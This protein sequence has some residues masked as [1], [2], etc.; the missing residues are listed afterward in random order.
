MTAMV[1][2]HTQLAINGGTPVRSTPFG[3][4]PLWD[5]RDEAALLG[6]LRSG[7]WGIGGDE[8]ERFEQELAEA[9]GARYALTVTNG[10]AA[11]EAAL[12]ACGVGYGDEVIVPPYTF[13]ATASAVLLVGGIP[14]FADI[15]PNTFNIDPNTIEALITPRTKAIVPVHIGGLPADMD[16]IM[17]IAKRHNLLVLEDA[18]QS[19]GATW[20]GQWVGTIGD[21]GCYSFQSS[22]NIN[23]GEGGVIITSNPE[24]EEACWAFK[25]CGRVR[26]GQWYQHDT[27]GDNFR[28][29]QFQAAILRSQMTRF[30]EWAVL[31]ER[32]GDY[33][34]KGLREL[35]GLA[36]VVRDE[37]VTRHAYHIIVTRYD[38]SAF[39]G[40]SR[41]RFMEA[42]KAE[43][44]PC[45]PGYRPIYTTGGIQKGEQ[46][47]RN[48]LGL[49]EAP[50]PN[51]P[52]TERI[53]RE[54]AMWLL[55]QSA[56]LGSQSDMDDILTAVEKI[57][58]AAQQG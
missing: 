2:Q 47:L 34:C 5:E 33:L 58:K 22:K 19:I 9:A 14:V 50:A 4:W 41:D 35:G 57:K 55:G 3:T 49:G 54:E 28:L 29:S 18:C 43:G 38:A 39:G 36:P 27:L 1:S 26:G 51:C 44:I 6:A 17:A 15:D 13:I 30:E 21:I 53:C 24:L 7:N 10:T 40:W 42:L 23:S 16:A 11:L 31:R 37:R 20:R 12:R 25:N 45:A 32:N 46:N 8:T 52:V 48:A 56:L